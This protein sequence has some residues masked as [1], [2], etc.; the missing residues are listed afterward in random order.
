ML[1][2]AERERE[3]E[4]ERDREREREIERERDR[5]EIV[6]SYFEAALNVLPAFPMSSYP[7][8]YARLWSPNIAQARG[9]VDF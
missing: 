3:R 7:N 9:S 8:G 4:R 5:P 2:T 1:K 6:L